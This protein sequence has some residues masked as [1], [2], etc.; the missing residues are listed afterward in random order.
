M[1][2]F[3]YSQSLFGYFL[4]TK[5]D[6]TPAKALLLPIRIFFSDEVYH[7]ISK[8]QKT[9][10]LSKNLLFQDKLIGPVIPNFVIFALAF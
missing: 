4:G 7:G 10:T 8:A 3:F 9:C 2:R 5:S 1:V 6:K